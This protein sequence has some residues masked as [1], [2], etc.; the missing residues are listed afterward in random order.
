MKLINKIQGPQLGPMR[1]KFEIRAVIVIA[2]VS[3]SGDRGKGSF[4]SLILNETIPHPF[5]NS[6][7]TSLGGFINIIIVIPKLHRLTGY[8]GGE[9]ILGNRRWWM[10]VGLGLG[11]EEGEVLVSRVKGRVYLLELRRISSDGKLFSH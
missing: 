6:V 1:I 2:E 9:G 3:R 5:L 7:N 10:L 11:K 4:R 8:G